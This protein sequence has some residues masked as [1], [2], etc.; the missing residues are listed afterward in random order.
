MAVEVHADVLKIACNLAM[1][2]ECLAC[3]CA[4][5]V[6]VVVVVLMP[7]R[8]SAVG[9]NTLEMVPLLLGVITRGC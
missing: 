3:W 4:L 7:A 5:I 1:Q 2:D 8:G 9:T 6:L